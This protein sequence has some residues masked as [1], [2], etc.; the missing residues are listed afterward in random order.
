MNTLSFFA[1]GIPVPQPRVKS[2]RIGMHSG[3]YTP[4][5][6]DS[7]KR[8]VTISAKQAWD[9]VTFTG[10]VMLILDL[11]LPRPKS[12]FNKAGLKPNAPRWH[13]SR[14][15]FDNYAKAIAD[16]FTRVGIWNDDG[17]VACHEFMKQYATPNDNVTCGAR[18]EVR[19]LI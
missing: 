18:I 9:K 14:G 4:D 19:E 16:A 8:I 13:T 7:W 11:Y 10:P 3:V 2:R 6:A 17:Q 15:D 1:A 12:H 5:T